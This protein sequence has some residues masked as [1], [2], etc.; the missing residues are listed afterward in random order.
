MKL[1][2]E[3]AVFIGRTFEEYC[4][5]FQLHDEDIQNKKILDCPSGACSFTAVAT[6]LP[7]VVPLLVLSKIEIPEW[8][9]RWLNHI[10]I[11]ILAALLA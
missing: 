1:N 2:I 4:D 9:L 5:M 10:P 11:A 3:R 6:F 7:R 8:G